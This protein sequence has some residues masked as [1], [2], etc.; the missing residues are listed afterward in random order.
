MIESAR[1][2]WERRAQWPLTLA[3]VLFLAAYAWPILEPDLPS[4]QVSA[5]LTLTWAMWA[6]FAVDYFMRLLLSR[7]RLR[8]VRSHLLDLALVVLPI[9]RPL[10]LLRLITLL[11][12]LNRYAGRSLRGRVI[13]YAAGSSMLIIFIAALAVLDA[14]RKVPEAS[15]TTFGDALWWAMTTV[16][17][18]G[19][20]DTYPVTETGRFIAGG[21]ML[22][23]I[24]LLGVVTAS[25]ASWLIERV[26]DLEEQSQAATRR[27]VE[28]L[29]REIA[30][31]RAEIARLTGRQTPSQP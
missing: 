24:A 10:R 16:T 26:A 8:F 12:V 13:A 14:E 9:F 4:R 1:R 3:A 7:N 20:G 22:S 23:G 28:A 17:T 6:L 25:L 21:L 29:S 19:Y 15:I 18:V 11:A 31:L 2:R 27:D 5:C 30:E